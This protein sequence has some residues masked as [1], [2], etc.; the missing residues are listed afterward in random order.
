MTIGSH[1]LI[2]RLSGK[3]ITV[4]HMTSSVLIVIL[5]GIAIL[6]TLIGYALV[7][8]GDERDSPQSNRAERMR[9]LSIDRTTDNLSEALRAFRWSIKNHAE[10]GYHDCYK[11]AEGYYYKD[12]KLH[13]IT[14]PM[15]KQ[16]GDIM[17]DDG[18]DVEFV[19]ESTI[20]ISW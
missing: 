14:A 6:F 16:I 15:L 1:G 4:Y 18:F 20:R 11:K 10:M 5:V 3:T 8:V 17:K 9:L 7:R 13:R 19:D 2:P 12:D